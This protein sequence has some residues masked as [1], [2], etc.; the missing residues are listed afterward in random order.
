MQQFK[1]IKLTGKPLSEEVFQGPW[2]TSSARRLR[3]R[4]IPLYCCWRLSIHNNAKGKCMGMVSWAQQ[5]SQQHWRMQQHQA[6]IACSLCNLKSQLNFN[7]AWLPPARPYL[8]WH[9]PCLAI[10]HRDPLQLETPLW[11]PA[12]PTVVAALVFIKQ[13]RAK[14]EPTDPHWGHCKGANTRVR[15]HLQT[16]GSRARK[17]V[18]SHSSRN[19]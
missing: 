10:Q 12:S 18:E 3:G 17:W 19:E 7:Q 14:V 5:P 16:S 8:L 11:Q 15:R 2:R 13:T 1:A 9:T 4:L 6:T